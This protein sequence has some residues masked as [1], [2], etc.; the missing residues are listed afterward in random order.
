MVTF[1]D[2]GFFQIFQR[3]WLAGNPISALEQPNS[4]VISEASMLKYFPGSQAD[5]V[6]GLEMD[7]ME[8]DTIQGKITGIIADST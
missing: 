2:P 8:S 7:Y 6:L 4:V 5:D 3:V 1:A